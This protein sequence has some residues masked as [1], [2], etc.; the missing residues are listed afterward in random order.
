ML[1]TE[2]F[3][4]NENFE[5]G[6]SEI[7]AQHRYLVDLLNR[8]VQCI[9]YGQAQIDILQVF[10]ELA[11]YAVYHFSAE[12]TI[13]RQYLDEG[14][15]DLA[16]THCLAHKQFLTEVGKLRSNLEAQDISLIMKEVISFLVHWLA[17]H[18]LHT[19]KHF[20]KIV[21]ALQKGATLSEAKEAADFAMSGAMRVLIETVL[22]MYDSLSSKTLELMCEMAARQR[23]EDRLRLSQK[24]IEITQDAIFVT[25]NKCRVID[26]NPAFC[27][28]VERENDAI[29]GAKVQELLPHL[30]TDGQEEA[31]L[32]MATDKG[33]W[34]G[35]IVGRN[36]NNQTDAVWFT[37]SAIKDQTG[38][39]THFAGI[40]SSITPLIEKQHK[41]TNAANH[42]MLTGLPNRRLLIDR[43]DQALFRCKRNGR[44]LAVCFMDLDGF[45]RINDDFGHE[46]GDEV[47]RTVASRLTA[48]LRDTDTVARLG[49]DEF[50]LL[51]EEN[52]STENHF[53]VLM[54]RVLQ[55]ISQPVR[56][57]DRLAQVTASIG[58]TFYPED[59][60]SID[61]L[62][63]HADHAM[64]QAKRR[65]KSVYHLFSSIDL[66]CH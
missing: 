44:K 4:W 24:V 52:L 56:F 39:L 35:E 6:F 36:A 42:D 58:V 15:D 40:L 16:T 21:F 49:G 22:K 7:D 18:I 10:D 60:S 61:E 46:A 13:W 11:N 59:K 65:G 64:Y 50:V 41:L 54:D 12:E 48:C 17:F 3:P 62:L 63:L 19:D 30:F 33:H 38:N 23:A 20:S 53:E 34:S 45:K 27:A 55:T 31:I 29:L 26:T 37:F 1:S 43:M 9:A 14:E 5:T 51:F 47:L 28:I 66:A 32:K 2:I 8:L 57:K 25:D